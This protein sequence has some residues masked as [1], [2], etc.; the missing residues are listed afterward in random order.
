MRP[1][2]RAVTR[3][4]CWSGSRDGPRHRVGL[5]SYGGGTGGVRSILPLIFASANFRRLADVL[6]ELGAWRK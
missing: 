2:V 1:S 3:V 4:R 5:G 6:D